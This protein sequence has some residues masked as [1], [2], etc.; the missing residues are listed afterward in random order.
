MLL[1]RLS[2]NAK[3]LVN[4]HSTEGCY[5]AAPIQHSQNK[6]SKTWRRVKR[7]MTSSLKNSNTTVEDKGRTANMKKCSNE[8]PWTAQC[9]RNTI[10]MT[11]WLLLHATLTIPQR[12]WGWP[13]WKTAF[14]EAPS[15]GKPPLVNDSDGN[16]TLADPHTKM[17][18]QIKWRTMQRGTQNCYACEKSMVLSG[19][20]TLSYQTRVSPKLYTESSRWYVRND[21]IILSDYEVTLGDRNCHC[22]D[23]LPLHIHTS[24]RRIY[25]FNL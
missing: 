1:L 9:W 24:E 16:R 15:W 22:Y 6:K 12:A 14:C 8:R 25:S 7:R 4:V 20:T 3:A 5:C 10:T 23:I 18:L 21:G 2:R 13:T 11:D 17:L 19:Q